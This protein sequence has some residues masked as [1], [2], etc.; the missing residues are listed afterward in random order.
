MDKVMDPLDVAMSGVLGQDKPTLDVEP[1]SDKFLPASSATPAALAAARKQIEALR[2]S[3]DQERLVAK[4]SASVDRFSDHA[5]FLAYASDLFAELARHADGTFD[6]DLFRSAWATTLCAVV[7]G[8]TTD[9]EGVAFIKRVE[10]MSVI[11]AGFDPAIG[12][13][14]EVETALK[15]FGKAG[16]RSALAAANALSASNP[17]LALEVA[18]GA[19]DSLGEV[20]VRASAHC[21]LG[22]YDD[23]V[24]L[25]DRLETLWGHGANDLHLDDRFQW[26]QAMTEVGRFHEA[27]LVVNQTVELIRMRRD[28]ARADADVLNTEG[29]NDDP[30]GHW[31]HVYTV[32]AGRLAHLQGRFAEGWDHFRAASD[33]DNESPGVRLS[34]LRLRLMLSDQRRA[35][36]IL[37]ELET[38]ARKEGTDEAQANFVDAALWAAGQ[39]GQDAGAGSRN[40]DEPQDPDERYLSSA[41]LRG[42]V[43]ARAMLTR[44]GKG[45][46]LGQRLRLALLAGDDRTAERILE[47]NPLSKSDPWPLKVMAAVLAI[48]TGNDEEASETLSKVLSSRRHDIDLRILHAQAELLGDRHKPAL[49]E[50]M[51][52]TESMPLHLVARVVRAECQLESAMEQRDDADANASSA[53]N[54]TLLLQ[55]AADYR[56]AADLHCSTREYLTT[57]RTDGPVGSE[58][59]SPRMFEEVCRRGLHAAILAQEDLDRLGLRG[60]RRLHSDAR[61]LLDH[62]R[63]TTRSCCRAPRRGLAAALHRWRHSFDAD[64]PA[65]LAGLLS[66]HRRYVW[67]NRFQGLL[68][69]ALGALVCWAALNNW[70]P[71][72]ASDTILAT[73]FALGVILLLMP[74]ARSLRI[75]AVEF[76]R[77]EPTAP[78]F[79]R[80][81]ALRTSSLMQ[82]GYHLGSFALPPTPE[83]GRSR[84]DIVEADLSA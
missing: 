62:L 47:K 16:P 9:E 27:E 78:A 75:G 53:D 5:P 21:E 38:V 61:A 18:E 50:A 31:G 81:R 6:P 33:D 30:T 28:E 59:L 48:R 12:Y 2:A 29:L 40:L 63:R 36:E 80:S 79:G 20:L 1:G 76:T 64:E 10:T 34:A 17:A 25:F 68:L 4:L 65:R 32:M 55:A 24:K 39:W 49:A 82:R 84:R 72:E 74:F 57:G 37:R 44:G 26:V 13:Y 7:P 67:R 56:L 77:P 35:A 11:G 45:M 15:S 14:E 83:K 46:D 66:A 23:A 42:Q 22:E 73:V 41:R 60:D 43:A 3:G 71:G 54:A 8:A 58:P 52:C 70:L 51:A 19:D 69:V